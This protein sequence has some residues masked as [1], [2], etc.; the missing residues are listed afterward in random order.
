MAESLGREL[1]ITHERVRQLEQQVV[2]LTEQLQSRA[3]RVED[4]DDELRTLCFLLTTQ[5]V[6][7]QTFR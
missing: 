4:V 3:E 1:Q 2:S 5:S 7:P 6:T